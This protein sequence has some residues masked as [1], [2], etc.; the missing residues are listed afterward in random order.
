MAATQKNNRNIN[1]SRIIAEAI[2]LEMERDETIVLLGED[3][4][5]I[6]GVFGAL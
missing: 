4:G 3:I 2:A 6:G 1:L 5:K